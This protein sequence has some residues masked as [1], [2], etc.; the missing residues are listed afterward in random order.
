MLKM[1]GAKYAS[2]TLPDAVNAAV[3]CA[4][5]AAGQASSARTPDPYRG[6]KREASLV[7]MRR[8]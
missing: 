6:V 8:T 5:I 2:M 4:A 3:P 7:G 1:V